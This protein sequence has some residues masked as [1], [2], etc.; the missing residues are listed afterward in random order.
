MLKSVVNSEEGKVSNQARKRRRLLSDEESQKLSRLFKSISDAERALREAIGKQYPITPD[1]LCPV[2]K[3]C[4]PEAEKSS[5][6][7]SRLRNF[8]SKLLSA[9][10]SN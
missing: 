6:L 7:L 8:I 3:A 1:Q 10:D 4:F 5:G 9:A 2:N